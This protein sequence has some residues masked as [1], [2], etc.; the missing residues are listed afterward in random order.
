MT[1]E[2]REEVSVTIAAG[3]TDLSIYVRP[4]KYAIGN[5]VFGF[6]SSSYFIAIA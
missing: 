5:T 1:F 6:F 2:N 4:V 3:G